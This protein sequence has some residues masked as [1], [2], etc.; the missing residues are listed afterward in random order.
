MLAVNILRSRFPFCALRPLLLV[1]LRRLAETCFSE[2]MVWFAHQLA[3]FG[4]LLAS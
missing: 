1:A 3:S 4:N 2:A